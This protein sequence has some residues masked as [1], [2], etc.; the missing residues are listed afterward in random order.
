MNFPERMGALA[1][2]EPTG[3]H[4]LVTLLS[5]AGQPQPAF[6]IFASGRSQDA[7]SLIWIPEA[8]NVFFT[9]QNDTDL[10]ER[11]ETPE[12]L[13]DCTFKTRRT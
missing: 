5:D 11:F 9:F 4:L 12:H 8:E 13:G 3:V 6:S 10:D 1:N 7:G 2:Q